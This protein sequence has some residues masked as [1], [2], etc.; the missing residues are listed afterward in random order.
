MRVQIPALNQRIGGPDFDVRVARWAVVPALSLG[1][2]YLMAV[3]F[4]QIAR[5]RTELIM[6][7]LGASSGWWRGVIEQADL[8]RSGFYVYDTCGH[9]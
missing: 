2:I 6:C 3:R 1:T 9:A 4:P 8:N 7:L 5:D